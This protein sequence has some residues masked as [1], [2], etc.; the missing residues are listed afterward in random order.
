MMNAAAA[1]DVTPGQITSAVAQLRQ[2]MID[3]LAAFVQCRS[4]PGQETPAAEFLERELA[5]L[6]L[7]TERVILRTEDLKDLPLYSPPC[8]PDGGR[9]NVLARHEIGRAHV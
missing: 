4:L 7:S 1:T 2:Y 6:G 8:C 5:S 9:Y 3:T